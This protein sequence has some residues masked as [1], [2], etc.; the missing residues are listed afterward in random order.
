MEKALRKGRS[1]SLITAV[2]RASL[3]RGVSLAFAFIFPNGDH[4]PSKM[5]RKKEAASELV[6]DAK[7]SRK[8]SPGELE[9]VSSSKPPQFVNEYIERLDKIL[10]LKVGDTR[11]WDQLSKWHN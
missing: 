7:K 11:K 2:P 9:L 1:E 5:K 8:Y 4:A 10:E 6:R 3:N